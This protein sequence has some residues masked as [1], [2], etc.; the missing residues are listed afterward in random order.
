MLLDEAPFQSF[1]A[2]TEND[3]APNVDSIFPLG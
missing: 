3:L 1:G 2:A